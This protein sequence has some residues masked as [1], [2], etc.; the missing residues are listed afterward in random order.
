MTT[1]REW[2]LRAELRA[3]IRAVKREEWLLSVWLRSG[4]TPEFLPAVGKA[5]VRLQAA[6]G[7]AERHGLTRAAKARPAKTARQRKALKEA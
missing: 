6:I 7:I 2:H 1:A 4:M 3:L 5:L